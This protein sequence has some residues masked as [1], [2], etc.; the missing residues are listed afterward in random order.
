VPKILIVGAGFS[1]GVLAEQLAKYTDNEI[2]VVDERSHVAG[3]CHT[4]RD[5]STGIMVHVYGP[6]IFNTSSETVWQ[7]VQQ[8]GEFS[9]YV[10]RV[11]AITNRGAF[12]LPINLLTINQVFGKTF[13]PREAEA[14]V[15]S[16]GIASIIEPRSLE[17]QALKFLG[18]TLYET[19]FR[20]YTLKQ[21]GTD[22][23]ELPAS[24]LKRLPIRFTY[25]DRFYSSDFQGIPVEGYTTIVGRM[26]ADSKITVRLNQ[27]YDPSWNKDFDY[28]FY[29]G[30]IDA[31]FQHRLGRLQYRTIYFESEIFAS[32]DYQGNPVINYCEERVPYTRIHEHRHFAPREQ[33]DRSIFFREFSKETGS[34]DLPYYP[35][36]LKSDLALLKKYRQLA[37]SEEKVSFIGRLGTYRYLDM[38]HVVQES[39]DLA[40]KFMSHPNSLELFPT[41]PN[42]EQL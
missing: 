20:G 4:E 31:Y 35:K 2:L 17:E 29:S 5:G 32:S 8:F 28:V 23:K 12:S 22:P 15:K 36:R 34:D 26:L 1:G 3:N 37:E 25:D 6:H 10:N 19:F 16:Q 7:Y 24:I 41:F 21:W 30:A 33:H 11:K 39:L 38:Q 27:K 40:T 9:S 42:V 13:N 18:P 14:F